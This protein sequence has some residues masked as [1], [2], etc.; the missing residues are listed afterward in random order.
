[1]KK[2][3]S[4][5][6]NNLDKIMLDK[7]MLKTIGVG[8]AG[9]ALYYAITGD[10]LPDGGATEFYRGFLEFGPAYV[11]VGTRLL[12]YFMKNRAESNG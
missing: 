4:K 10:S 2:P 8:V 3:E 5:I 6:E 11:L 12:Q 7:M 1:M 9:E